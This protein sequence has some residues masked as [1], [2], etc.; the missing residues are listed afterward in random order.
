M[1]RIEVQIKLRHEEMEGSRTR[2]RCKSFLVE[3]MWVEVCH[4]EMSIGN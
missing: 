4:S 2:R 3:G 1:E